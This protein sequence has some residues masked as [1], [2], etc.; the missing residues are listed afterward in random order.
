MTNKKSHM[1]FRLVPKSTTL[2][3]LEGPLRI[4]RASFGAHHKSLNEDRLQGDYQRRRCSP[5]TLDSGNTRFMR[6][7]AVV[8]KICVNFPDFTP[9][10]LYYV[11]TYLTLFR[12]QVQ[13]F[14]LWQLSVN[15]AAAG[16]KVRTSEGVASGLA[17]CDPQSI[18]NPQKNCGSFVDATSS[19]SDK[20]LSNT[21][22]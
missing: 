22:Y 6:I 16:C 1:C 8:L 10:P 21:K 12:Y 17:K 11:Y 20:R 15:T 18:W 19:I 9:A 3:D 2:D 5:M 4:T 14:C 13:L 7:F